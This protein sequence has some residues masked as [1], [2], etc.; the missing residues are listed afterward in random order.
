MA[1]QADCTEQQ[2]DLWLARTPPLIA[3]EEEPSESDGTFDIEGGRET[4]EGGDAV[5]SGL[6]HISQLAPPVGFLSDFWEGGWDG[7]AI[8]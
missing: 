8:R 4:Q 3:L 1:C 2:H 7:Q 5:V 6:T